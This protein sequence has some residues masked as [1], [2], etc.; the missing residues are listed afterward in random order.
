MKI[1]PLVLLSLV[2]LLAPLAAEDPDANR[3]T[4]FQSLN[5][6]DR[7]GMINKSE[8]AVTE[9]FLL[10]ALDLLN[11][12][13]IES[14][15]DNE[16]QQKHDLALEIVQLLGS[17]GTTKS[18][19]ALEL[20]VR[21]VNDPLLKGQ[22]W[23]VLAAKGDASI[24]PSLVQSLDTLNVSSQRTH[25]QEILAYKAVAAL[26]ALK[27]SD[28]FRS[29]LTASFGWYSSSSQ[30]REL[31]LKTVPLLSADPEASAISLIASEK[32]VTLVNGWFHWILSQGHPQSQTKASLTVLQ[33][34]AG[35]VTNDPDQ[36]TTAAALSQQALASIVPGTG[37]PQQVADRVAPFLRRERTISVKT[38]AVG[39][40]GA[41]ANAPCAALL[42]S[43]LSQYND[44]QKNGVNTAQDQEVVRSLVK[45]LGNAKR[46]EGR[47]A[48]QEAR[49]VGYTPALVQQINQALASLAP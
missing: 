12:V 38:Q 9:D 36:L 45:A 24:V 37:D 46:G 11:S 8:A 25:A 30:V 20:L 7:L 14:G 17:R 19:P 15:S 28:G 29:V 21:Q 35:L 44:R 27:A 26:G 48:L 33:V 34:L 16:V 43:T 41:E 10:K 13:Q 47:A 40:L 22:A 32:D 18:L 49:Y 2:T 39:L 3:W 23:A 31:A 1:L 6:S 4:L 5:W 42:G